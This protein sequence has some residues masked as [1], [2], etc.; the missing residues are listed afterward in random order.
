MKKVELYLYNSS[1]LMGVWLPFAIIML[2]IIII[3][4]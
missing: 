1:D 4:D 3:I 2:Q